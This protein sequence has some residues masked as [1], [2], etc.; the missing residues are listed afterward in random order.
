MNQIKTTDFFL[1]FLN[2][3]GT[4]NTQKYNK[5]KKT[6]YIYDARTQCTDFVA[7]VSWLGSVLKPRRC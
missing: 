4:E 5:K 3:L 1:F 2:S 7:A 6:I